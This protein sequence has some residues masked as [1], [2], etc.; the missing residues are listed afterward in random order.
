MLF[1]IKIH[2]IYNLYKLDNLKFLD[3]EIWNNNIASYGIS[4]QYCAA[5]RNI[6]NPFCS[7]ECVAK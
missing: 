5:L 1:I 4:H 2:Y 6:S 7:I 3:F